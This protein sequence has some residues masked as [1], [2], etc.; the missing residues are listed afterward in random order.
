MLKD[1]KK[2]RDF[3]KTKE[4]EGK[5]GKKDS[6]IFVVQKHDASHLHYDLRLSMDGVLKSWALPKKPPE[7]AGVK[8]L[9]VETE[10]HPLSY[11]DF[12]GKIPE[13]QYGAG[14]VEIWDKGDYELEKGKK[15]KIEV[16][17]K[18]EK[19]KGAYALIKFKGKK[20]WLFFKMKK[21]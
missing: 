17:L 12:E 11:A 15:D 19:L 7:R 3:S 14:K 10:D 16:V 2:K 20:N 4:P 6:R 1:Y 5:K 13:G 8:R 9:A 18:G 21:G